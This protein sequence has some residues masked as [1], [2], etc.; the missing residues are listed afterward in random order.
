MFTKAKLT[1]YQKIGWT[2]ECTLFTV[3][4]FTVG[5]MT[6]YLYNSQKKAFGEKTVSGI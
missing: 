1:S 5:Y 6:E 2:K 4:E 3:T